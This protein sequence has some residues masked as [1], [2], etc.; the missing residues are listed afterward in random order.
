MQ[1]TPRNL[2]LKHNTIP[3]LL[4]INRYITNIRELN[5]HQSYQ[6][7]NNKQLNTI[8]KTGKHQN[9]IKASTTSELHK[10]N[11]TKNNQPKQQT[12]NKQTNKQQTKHKQASINYS[13]SMQIPKTNI[14]QTTNNK[15]ITSDTTLLKHTKPIQNTANRKIKTLNKQISHKAS[16]HHNKQP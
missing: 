4:K 12:T 9:H 13:K 15:E 10:L 14:L 6:H 3:T 1:I 2:H 5:K 16:Q 11:Q 7:N 8:N